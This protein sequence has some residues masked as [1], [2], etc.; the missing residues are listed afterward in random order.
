MLVY[1]LSTMAMDCKTPRV[2]TFFLGGNII[3][4]IYLFSDFYRKA[5]NKKNQI[6]LELNANNAKYNKKNGILLN[7]DDHANKIK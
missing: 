6:A 2:L 3:I 1:L 5:Y 7:K 4:F